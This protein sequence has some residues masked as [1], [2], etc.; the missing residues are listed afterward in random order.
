MHSEHA[1]TEKDE[2]RYPAGVTKSSHTGFTDVK[3]LLE[4]EFS[5]SIFVFFK[6]TP[7][8]LFRFPWG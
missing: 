7:F 5:E 2:V 1:A 6:S 8:N 3:M 4:I